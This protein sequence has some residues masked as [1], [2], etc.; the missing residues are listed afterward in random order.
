MEDRHGHGYTIWL[1]EMIMF[2]EKMW[3]ED[4]GGYFLVWFRRQGISVRR[5]EVCTNRG[6]AFQ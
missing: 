4:Q 3:V 5:S 6:M 2:I 1:C